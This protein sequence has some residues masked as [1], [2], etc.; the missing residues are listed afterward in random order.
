M[1]GTK[2]GRTPR[3]RTA[4]SRAEPAATRSG[5][6]HLP[7]RPRTRRTHAERRAETRAKILDAVVD[8][9]ADL[10]VQRT[11]AQVIAHRAGVTW[12]A[13]QHHFGDKD[14]LLLAVLEESFHRF[15]ERIGDI[16]IEG[17]SLPERAGI[18]VDRAW[19]HFRS[20]YFRSTFE[21]LLNYLGREEHEAAVD[22]RLRMAEAWN[23]VWSR[24][25]AD[26]TATPADFRA[27][28]HFTISSLSGLAQ[29]T[30]LAGS[31]GREP[32]RELELLRQTL[33]RAL[34]GS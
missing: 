26:A 4:A 8:A 30:M 13:V 29:T 17:S 23:G 20:P 6:L 24:V 16:R 32:K 10:G 11:T 12:G 22:W 1:A 19:E 9:I 28:Q 14:A 21:I 25:F 33:A 2:S 18:F 34:K 5:R 27:A 3:A 15:A 31:R 7:P